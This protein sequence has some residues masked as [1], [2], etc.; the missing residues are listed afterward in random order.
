MLVAS[1]NLVDR[2]GADFGWAVFKGSRGGGD[3]EGLLMMLSLA[4]IA[5]NIRMWLKSKY[6]LEPNVVNTSDFAA[7]RQPILI[8][9]GNCSGDG[10]VPRRTLLNVK[11]N[12]ETCNS[13]DFVLASTLGVRFANPSPRPVETG[14]PL[15]A[16]SFVGNYTGA[17]VN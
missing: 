9:C 15:P 6:H 4:L 12:C 11:G 14:S 17:L 7:V 1:N 2:P 16:S 13:S 8:V 3:M 5:L 10:P